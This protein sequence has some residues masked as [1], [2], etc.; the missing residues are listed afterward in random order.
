MDLHGLSKGPGF[1]ESSQI[2]KKKK[3]KVKKRNN[4]NEPQQ[5]N[6]D[7]LATAVSTRAAYRSPSSSL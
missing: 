4:I 6:S 3:A 7:V 2:K 5:C 1:C